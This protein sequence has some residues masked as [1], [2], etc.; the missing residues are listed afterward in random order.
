[1]LKHVI[2]KCNGKWV[3]LRVYFT[4]QADALEDDVLTKQPPG[5]GTQG[6]ELPWF[7]GFYNYRY[8]LTRKHT[9]Q[10]NSMQML[11]PF[12]GPY[13]HQVACNKDIPAFLFPVRA[14]PLLGTAWPA[15]AHPSAT[16]K[17]L[18]VS[19][20]LDEA[21]QGSSRWNS[22]GTMESESAPFNKT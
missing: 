21:S 19:A 2:S 6:T 7:F 4:A 8:F 11:R 16:S 17:V 1:M 22:Q 15:S 14:L 20:C 12:P 18:D 9:S 3:R 5:C 13:A 10:P